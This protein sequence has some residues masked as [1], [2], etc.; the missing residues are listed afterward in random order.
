MSDN[1]G[2]RTLAR[3]DAFDSELSVQSAGPR[4][5]RVI[6][7]LVW[8]GTKGNRFVVPVGFITDFATV[9][10]VMH[11]KVSPYGP[12]TRAAVLHDY[13]LERLKAG[14]RSIT[15]RDIDGIFRRAME[16]LGVRWD[17]RWVMWT[18]VRWGALF[19]G[20]R[21]YERG[22]VRDLPRVLG[23]SIIALGTTLLGVVGVSIS[24]AFE[25]IP[26]AIHR[27]ITTSR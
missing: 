21:S 8:E 27:L 20:Y 5:W 19:S 24:L 16:D 25:A 14:D 2:V 4:T 13:L 10:R 6:A 11:W 9:P 1:R 18:G 26:N 7:P 15:S 17:R 3:P 23:I 12:Y 22:F